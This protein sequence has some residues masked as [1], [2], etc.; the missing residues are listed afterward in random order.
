L[1]SKRSNKDESR[2]DQSQEKADNQPQKKVV[3]V[4][5]LESP[6]KWQEAIEIEDG[7]VVEV[8]AVADPV[9]QFLEKLSL[10]EHSCQIFAIEEKEDKEETVA[11]DMAH[12]RVVPAVINGVGVRLANSKA[13]IKP[14]A[15]LSAFD[16]ENSIEFPLDSVHYLYKQSNPNSVLFILCF[17]MSQLALARLLLQIKRKEKRKKNNIQN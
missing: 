4:N 2:E 6:E 11:P 7:K 16:K 15:P 3:L 14:T 8:W 5:S 10:E 13:G 17:L 12:L 9:L 1:T